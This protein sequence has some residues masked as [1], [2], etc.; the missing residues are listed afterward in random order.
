M[1]SQRRSLSQRCVGVSPGL[2]VWGVV[3]LSDLAMRAWTDVIPLDAGCIPVLELPSQS[4]TDRAAERADV[5]HY[6]SWRLES[7]IKELAGLV[8]PEASLF[9]LQTSPSPCVPAG[10]CL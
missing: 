7:R 4:V 5:Y 8:L 3:S 1:L 6:Q 10:S 2:E 9:G